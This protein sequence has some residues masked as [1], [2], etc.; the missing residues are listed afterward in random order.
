MRTV[1]S[2]HAAVHHALTSTHF[3]KTEVNAS[4]TNREIKK[5]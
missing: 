2:P 5:T 4:G 3:V 1:R